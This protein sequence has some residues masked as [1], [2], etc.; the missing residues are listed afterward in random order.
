M[1]R[2][3]LRTDV[4]RRT[5]PSLLPIEM[6]RDVS[7]LSSFAAA[8]RRRRRHFARPPRGANGI[9]ACNDPRRIG[10]RSDNRRESRGR[11]LP[12]SQIT[13]GWHGDDNNATIIPE[14]ARRKGNSVGGGAAIVY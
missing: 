13:A 1:A 8:A 9:P 5:E 7:N 11:D 2:N 14:R 6:Y 10:G 3:G 12:L 4:K